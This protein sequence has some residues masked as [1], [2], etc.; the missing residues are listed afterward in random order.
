LI[1]TVLMPTESNVAPPLMESV[2]PELVPVLEMVMV[3][4]EEEPPW[5]EIFTCNTS[6]PPEWLPLTGVKLVKLVGFQV[7]LETIVAEPPPPPDANLKRVNKPLPDTSPLRS[8]EPDPSSS[9]KSVP[10]D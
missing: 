4:V 2:T 6:T 9:M 7:P 8:T 5:G 3:P 1:E 10:P